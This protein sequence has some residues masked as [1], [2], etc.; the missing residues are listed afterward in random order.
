MSRFAVICV[1]ALA[2]AGCA[3]EAGPE[4]DAPVND[5]AAPPPPLTT[6]MVGGSDPAT[7][8]PVA[9]TQTPVAPAGAPQA[10]TTPAPT[11]A[12]AATDTAHADSAH[13][14]H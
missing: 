9:P 7:Q 10:T 5:A 14:D 2:M 4:Q 1:M 13:T 11:I 6:K 8:P 12:P 3:R